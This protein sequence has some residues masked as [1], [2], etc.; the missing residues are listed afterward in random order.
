MLS[1]FCSLVHP[2]SHDALQNGRGLD[3]LPVSF[4]PPLELSPR[5]E[6]PPPTSIAPQN[7]T[8]VTRRKLRF[9]AK[10]RLSFRFQPKVNRGED[11]PNNGRWLECTTRT[12]DS[13]AGP[14]FSFLSWIEEKQLTLP[15]CLKEPDTHAS[16]SSHFLSRNRSSL[17]PQN[18]RPQRRRLFP[19]LLPPPSALKPERHGLLERNIKYV[20]QWRNKAW[21]DH[22]RPCAGA[23]VDQALVHMKVRRIGECY[24]TRHLCR[25]RNV[26]LIFGIAKGLR[27]QL[28]FTSSP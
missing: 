3:L 17:P 8:L 27:L 21:S 22:N 10:F 15:V 1:L 20:R 6:A 26:V 28:G 16:K 25:L 12:I 4:A 11:R 14:F 13:L 24:H 18:D 19:A 5:Q 7:E 23:S 2:H 9:E